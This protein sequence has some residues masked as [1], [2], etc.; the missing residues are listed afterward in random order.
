MTSQ[1][2][3]RGI[4]NNNPLNIRR[5]G[6]KWKGLS[7]QQTDKAFCQF[8]E[9][10]YG[11]RAAF[12]LLCY[13]YWKVWGCNSVR[14]IISRWAPDNENNTESYIKRVC[15]LTGLAPS[16]PIGDPTQHADNW[17]K[18]GWAMAIVENGLEACKHLDGLDEHEGFKL[19]LASCYPEGR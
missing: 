18:L 1:M 15:E 8:D 4:R 7:K 16:E 5:S 9:M 6:S 10:K 13:T 3:P 19:A 11:W 14:T 2:K 17:L 12:Y